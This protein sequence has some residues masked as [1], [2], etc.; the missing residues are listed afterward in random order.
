MEQRWYKPTR[1]AKGRGM[2]ATKAAFQE[3]GLL[4]SLVLISSVAYGSV[5]TP[6]NSIADGIWKGFTET[7]LGMHH[8]LFTLL[9]GLAAYTMTKRFKSPLFYL[10][11]VLAGSF[12]QRSMPLPT[13]VVNLGAACSLAILLLMVWFHERSR[14]FFPWIFLVGGWFHGLSLA[15]EVQGSADPGFF[16]VVCAAILVQSLI[17]FGFGRFALKLSL[18]S[19]DGFEG[20]ENILSATAIGVAMAY[21]YRAF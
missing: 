14:A 13:L 15:N 8:L 2:R 1:I 4:T 18:Q 9:V 6:V 21:V 3:F 19:P 5:P 7:V 10:S 12:L 11:A 20:L 16:A 17:C